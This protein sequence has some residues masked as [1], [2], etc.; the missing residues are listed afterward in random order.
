MIRESI[1][2]KIN[3]NLEP[4]I[5]QIIAYCGNEYK[6]SIKKRASKIKLSIIKDEGVYSYDQGEVYVGDE[7]LCI[8]ENGYS[9]IVLPLTIIGDRHGNV[10]FIHMLLHAI[11]EEIFIKDNKDAF[12]ETVVDYMANDIAQW[13]KEHN[14]NITTSKN[15]SYE[16]NSFYSRLFEKI[17]PFYAYNKEK[18]IAGR[19]GNS[20]YFDEQDK[21]IDDIQTIVDKVFQVDQEE[22]NINIK[23]GK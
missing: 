7:P 18:I 22:N 4:V 11:G 12:N 5:D 17:E 2:K 3:S 10:V 8:K 9:H 19:L 16:S 21:Y 23:L 20:V 1:E 6:D 15:P 13:L 14:I